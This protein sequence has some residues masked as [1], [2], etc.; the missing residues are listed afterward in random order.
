MADDRNV[1]PQVATAEPASQPSAPV[2]QPQASA[3]VEENTNG[4]APAQAP[5][6]EKPKFDKFNGDFKS[7]PPEFADYAK[8]M[9]RYLTER[10][11][12]IASYKKAAEE[13]AAL[14]SDP[15]FQGALQSQ[16]QT[17]PPP[18]QQA[19]PDLYVDPDTKQ[20]VEK[21]RAQMEAQLQEIR[22]QQVMLEKKAE[23]S[24]FADLHPE[25]W[26]Y[27]ELGLMDPAIRVVSQNGG[28]VED[29]FNLL[30]GAISKVKESNRKEVLAELNN[31][32]AEKKAAI[33]AAPSTAAEADVVYVDDARDTAR[34]AFEEAF[35]G[36]NRQ[37]KVRK[38]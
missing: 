6:V 19:E 25:F 36:R 11:Q 32:A 10:T 24:S 8:S 21:T 5:V 35:S 4:S 28:S 33:S 30:H 1:Q 12:E 37:V 7:V 27:D 22:T 29:A 34:A 16:Q 23:L 14:K 38:K 13:Y 2:S 17:T 15:R 9:R 3:P 31:R 20:F 18:Q 26:E